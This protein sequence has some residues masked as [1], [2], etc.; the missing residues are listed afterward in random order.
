[1]EAVGGIPVECLTAGELAG[2][3][4]GW[5]SMGD[6][7]VVRESSAKG[8][9]LKLAHKFL[10]FLAKHV[11]DN[12]GFNDDEI[13]AWTIIN[14]IN[15]H[16][17]CVDSSKNIIDKKPID[18]ISINEMMNLQPI[19]KSSLVTEIY[20]RTNESCLVKMLDANSVWD[21]LLTEDNID[22]LI[23]WIDKKYNEVDIDEKENIFNHLE[24]DEEMLDNIEQSSAS[25]PTKE[26]LL[27]HL[28]K[29][30][31]FTKKER[32]DVKAMLA[33]FFSAEIT[34]NKINNILTN[35]LT[36]VDR[37]YFEKNIH[38]ILYYQN[39][40]NIDDNLYSN[41][42]DL[43]NNLN[44]ISEAESFDMNLL[45]R[46]ICQTICKITDEQDVYFE[47]H[48]LITFYLILLKYKSQES[49]DN[50]ISLYDM[51]NNDNGIVIDN[52]LLSRNIIIKIIDKIVYV[53]DA[54]KDDNKK[55]DITIYQLLNGY[56]NIDTQKLFKWRIK[57]ETIPNFAN[58]NLIKK[59]GRNEKLTYKYYLKESRPSMAAYIVQKQINLSSKIKSQFAFQA[60]IFG[61]DHVN[62]PDIISTC[63]AFIEFLGIDS[64]YLRL[65]TTVANYIK[66]ILNISINDLLKSITYQNSKDLITVLTYLEESFEIEYKTTSMNNIEKFILSLHSWSLIVQFS[67]AHNTELSS[68]F[69]KQLAINN[70]WFEFILVVH[71][72]HYPL[73][74]ILENT[75]NFND[76]NIREHL[77]KCLNNYHLVEHKPVYNLQRTKQREGKNYIYQKMSSKESPSP[78][79]N[80]EMKQLHGL[81]QNDLSCLLNQ[82]NSSVKQDLWLVILESHQSQD[83]PGALIKASCELKSPVLVVLAACYEP[84]SIAV[85]CYSWLVIS[86]DDDEFISSY[87][88]C[89]TDQIWSARKISELFKSMVSLG[90]LDT[91][92]RGLEIFLPD[93]PLCSFTKFIN[94]CIKNGQFKSN[95]KYLCEFLNIC[96]NLKSN[97]MIDWDDVDTTYLTNEFWIGT[98][99]IELVLICLGTC[100][101][102]IHLQKK[103][104]NILVDDNFNDELN[105]NE[106][107][108]CSLLQIITSL[109]KT[110]TKIN[111]IKIKLTENGTNVN[112]EIERCIEELVV[113]ENFSNAL[114]LSKI[115]NLPCSKIILNQYRSEFKKNINDK[116][117]KLNDNFWKKCADDIKKYDVGFDDTAKFFIE[118]AELVESYKERYEILELALKTLKTLSTDQQ[119]IDMVEMIMWKS[120]ILAGPESIV[121]Q[122][123]NQQFNKLKCELL[124]GISNLRV[125]CSLNDKIEEQSVE[126]LINKFID[127]EDLKTALRISAI[128]NYKH[129]DL[130]KLMLCLSLAEGEI[131]PYQMNVQ[132][133]ALLAESDDIKQQKYPTLKNRGLQKRLSTSSLNISSDSIDTSSSSSPLM[134]QKYIDCTLVL[135]KLIKSLQHGINVGN[136]IL[137]LHKLSG[138]LKRSYKILLLSTDPMIMLYEITAINCDKKFEL[139]NDVIAAYK[140]KNTEVTKF[141]AGEIN[142]HITRQIEDGQEDLMLMWGYPID[143]CL[144]RIADLCSDI[145]LLG[146]ELIKNA[147]SRLGHSHGT[148][149]D[150]S[151]LKIIVELLVTSHNYFTASCSM[152]G[153]ASVLKKCQQLANTLQR[154]KLWSLLVRL[155]TGVGRFTEMNYVF[156]IIKENDQFE[157]LLGQGMDK[158]SGLKIALLEFCKKQCPNDKELFTLV[159]LHFRLYNEIAIMW[160]TAAKIIIRELIKDTR[161][162]TQKS[163]T[164]SQSTI[165]FIKNDDTEK[166]LQLAIANFTHATEYYLQ[167][168]KLNL[169][170]K[171][172]HQ[173][174][175][176]ALQISLL[177]GTAPNQQVPC[178]LNLSVDEV[179]RALCQ[180]LNFSQSLI[181]IQAYNHSADWSS[182]IYHQ[183][184]ING[185]TKYLKDFLISKKLTTAIVQ[186]CTY[187]YRTEKNISKQM[188]TN[189]KNLINELNDVE[190]K[191]V[192]AS[193][194]GFKDIIEVILSNPTTG[195]YLKDTVWKQGFKS[196]EFIGETFRG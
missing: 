94:E 169:A 87:A 82:R 5:S 13:E 109:S 192:L 46:C 125:S 44:Q 185:K 178:L 102:S 17:D 33:R 116:Q 62:E 86:V 72:F 149:L 89:L 39:R 92:N 70:Y 126:K 112:E 177:N 128:F 122:N 118:H 96:S 75:V 3:W 119:T 193:Q 4:S 194:L 115:A 61:L 141:L 187:R 77:L 47:T 36:N 145:S 79:I 25:F 16:D 49:E 160:E 66:K 133:K 183:F 124:S 104:L 188:T 189:M 63:I 101:N 175:L 69:L 95:K 67:R 134:Q 21:Y 103:F 153:I 34:F 59:Y 159:A 172:S 164:L 190:C 51:I 140:I 37:E 107:D 76:P 71:I 26:L 27:N 88:D 171:C 147:S 100:F 162:N 148:K 22:L 68:W 97:K 106:P 139:I 6:R 158:I 57:N 90:Y 11:M 28:S 184:I 81:L 24:I 14:C 93:N 98:V 58:D 40:D 48:P 9:H 168:N 117:F 111:F 15:K 173:A 31:V 167:D 127:I 29:Y 52:V 152:E 83:P 121:I 32:Q 186:D 30:G 50:K 64:E 166:K 43:L 41:D 65:H 42:Q 176:V 195:S 8:T 191:Y 35:K 19:V 2:V 138:S 38:S 85:Y 170:N 135:E 18:N 23:N 78:T 54:I 53:K 105:I 131:S 73:E 157:F 150:I 182:S 151:A 156:Q 146:W 180:I 20:F 108:F 56:K 143:G 84:S 110:T 10:I 1:M 12:K 130:L 129:K 154:L 74:Q 99:A 113:K 142:L 163:P 45:S 114:E 144:K 179:N 181:I 60:H 174:Q 7:E 55:N 196:Q 165:K 161:K 120:C 136:K 155:V 80:Q 91:L 132:Q 123:D 137:L